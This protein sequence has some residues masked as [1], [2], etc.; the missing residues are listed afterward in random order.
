M[1][2][3]AAA[4]APAVTDPALFANGDNMDDAQ[5]KPWL[6][7]MAEK[8]KKKIRIMDKYGWMP[9]VLQQ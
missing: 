9:S 6:Q 4:A 5:Y 1:D 3:A 2:P 8:E 7:Q